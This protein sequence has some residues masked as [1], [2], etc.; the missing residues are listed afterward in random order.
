MK[1]QIEKHFVEEQP[2]YI[3]IMRDHNQVD[4][5]FLVLV[6][7]LLLG[8]IVYILYAAITKKGPEM[9]DIKIANTKL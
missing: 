5:G 1:H 8:A 4:N 3:Q 7:V 2:A 6:Y 9:K